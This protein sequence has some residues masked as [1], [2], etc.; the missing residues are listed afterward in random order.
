MLFLF[1][2]NN[3]L[4]IEFQFRMHHIL[5]DLQQKQKKKTSDWT[6][7]KHKF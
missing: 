2:I 6:T 5:Q 7:L 1:A 4:A 3:N